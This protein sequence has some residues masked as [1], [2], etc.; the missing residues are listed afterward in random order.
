ML[1]WQAPFPST[2]A[3]QAGSLDALG[4]CGDG[5]GPFAQTYH[6][7]ASPVTKREATLEV[8]TLGLLG[9]AAK[10]NQ[11]ASRN[12]DAYLLVAAC[13]HNAVSI[14]RRHINKHQVTRT[15]SAW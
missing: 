10:G 12:G 2:T 13:L 4:L 1:T 7:K 9:G 8:R 3:S 5:A 15:I 6:G 11:L 14:G